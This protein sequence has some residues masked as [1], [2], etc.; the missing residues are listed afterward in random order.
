[1]I[2]SISAPIRSAVAGA[3]I[4]ALLRLESRSRGKDVARSQERILA[5]LVERLGNASWWRANGFAPLRGLSGSRLVDE[6]RRSVRPVRYADLERPLRRV[7]RGEEDVLFPGRAVALAQTSG[8]TS[9]SAA[10]ERFVPQNDP[11]L[12][13]HA[14]GAMASLLRLCSAGSAPLHGRLLM[15]G[16]STALSRNEWGIPTG[17]LSGITVSRIPW[18]LRGLYEPGREIALEPD[19]PRKLDLIA[20]RLADADVTLV[21]GVPSW[22]LVLFDAVCRRRSVAR[23]RDAWPGLRGFVHGGASIDPYVPALRAHLPEDCLLQE[24]YPSS[25]AFLAIGS[26]PWRIAEGRAPDLEPLAEHGVFL[27]FLGE[28]CQD[29]SEAT[30]PEGLVPGRVYRV[31]VTT[32]GGLVRYELGDLVEGRPDGRL[33]FA[34]RIR[35]RISVFGEHVEGARLAEAIGNAC[36]ETSSAC[37]EFHVA[38]ILPTGGEPRGAHEWWIE[39]ARAPRDPDAFMRRVDEHLRAGVMDY[40]A[41]RVGDAQLLPPRARIVPE[42]TFHRALASIGKLGGQHKVPVAWPDRTWADR[43]QAHADGDTP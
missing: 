23:I 34:G 20:D 22:C 43:L 9:D 8:T 18:Y 29:P 6:F 5:S 15:L 37:R 14:R 42:G 35:A 3:A 1:M 40:D 27:E 36:D 33:R 11:L 4:P 26:R 41:H 24:V 17:D 19:W 7:A 2:Q 25:E 13:H 30:G 31:L 28:D 12:D 10:G 39:F 21:S 32:P 38:P 16:G